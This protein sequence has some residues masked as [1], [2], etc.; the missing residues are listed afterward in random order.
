MVAVK[1]HIRINIV[2]VADAKSFRE[3]ML[4][5]RNLHVAQIRLAFFVDFGVHA[6]T[7]EV[8]I[9]IHRLAFQGSNIAEHFVISCDFLSQLK[10]HDEYCPRG[11]GAHWGAML[12][13]RLGRSG[14]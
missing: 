6:P 3:G 10:L 1:G 4:I 14:E 5:G 12:N 11:Q 8:G 2:V 9:A 13:D 7:R